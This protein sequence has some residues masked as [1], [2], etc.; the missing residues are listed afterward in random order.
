MVFRLPEQRARDDQR[1]IHVGSTEAD[2]REATTSGLEAMD[3]T[4]L[5][6][7]G[8]LTLVKDHA[9]TRLLRPFEAHRH[10]IASDVDDRA[11]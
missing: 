11:E 7:F 8:R 1:P 9:I 4:A 6:A 10:A 5:L 3:E 2:E